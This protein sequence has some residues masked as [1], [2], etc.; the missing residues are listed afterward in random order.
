VVNCPAHNLKES[1]EEHERM[2]GQGTYPFKHN[3]DPYL[4]EALWSHLKE[5]DAV[6]TPS[7]RSAK[8]IRENIKPKRIEVIR[9]GVSLPEQV[10]YPKKFTNIGYIGALGPDKGLRYL[11][12]AWSKLN[13]DDSTLIFFGRGSKQMKPILEQWAT[14]GKY[15]LYG[16]FNSLDEIMPLFSVYVH[17]SVSE[18]FGLT[19]LESMAYGKIIVGSV[20]AG[21]AELIENGRS[22]FT[23]PVRDVDALATCIDDL[24]NNF[25]NLKYM[26]M[27]AR[28]TAEQNSWEK[29]ELKYEKLYAELTS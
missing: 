15:H 22:G 3:T 21:S 13:Y 26:A 7:S 25:D 5:A 16:G 19:L 29:I 11:V 24:K 1:I 20:G 12:E 28:K 14:G 4:R 18:G 27:N 6:I 2:Y 17:P 23:F 8:W 10:N 9:H